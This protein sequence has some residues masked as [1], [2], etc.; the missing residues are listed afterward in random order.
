MTQSKVEDQLPSEGAAGRMRDIWLACLVRWIVLKCRCVCS[1]D[2]SPGSSPPVNLSACLPVHLSQVLL[3][4]LEA[5]RS[6][7]AQFSVLSSVWSTGSTRPSQPAS[8]DLSARRPDGPVSWSMTPSSHLGDL[9]V[10]VVGARIPL[11]FRLGLAK[12]LL[13]C[14]LSLRQSGWLGPVPQYVR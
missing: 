9:A 1:I 14:G 3:W 5:V 4:S 12:A 11:R 6:T 8:H 10:I 2:D 7:T 13:V